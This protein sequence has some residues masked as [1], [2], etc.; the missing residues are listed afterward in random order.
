MLIKALLEVYQSLSRERGLVPQTSVVLQ[1]GRWARPEGGTNCPLLFRISAEPFI[2]WALSLIMLIHNPWE[3]RS[4]LSTNKCSFPAMLKSVLY[5]WLLLFTLTWK[6]FDPGS[7]C[8]KSVVWSAIYLL[9]VDH[10]LGLNAAMVKVCPL[11][12]PSEFPSVNLWGIAPKPSAW[13]VFARGIGSRGERDRERVNWKTFFWPFRVLRSI[14]IQ[15][16][17]EDIKENIPVL[18]RFK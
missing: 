3:M 6:V 7:E 1:G 17:H 12:I 18:F 2:S 9:G 11:V 10:V 4:R 15:L 14:Q 16:V 13:P 5:Y 8:L